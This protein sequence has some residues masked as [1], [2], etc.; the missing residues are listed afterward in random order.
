MVGH[1]SALQQSSPVFA[2]IVSSSRRRTMGYHGSGGALLEALE[3]SSRRL[4]VTQGGESWMERR[5]NDPLIN[6]SMGSETRAR[7]ISADDSGA[8][9][10]G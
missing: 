8:I 4:G 3:S 10:L 5:L 6:P 2:G 1:A 9:D 7:G